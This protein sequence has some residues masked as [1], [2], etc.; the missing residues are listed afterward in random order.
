MLLAHIFSVEWL[1]S[2]LAADPLDFDRQC[3][4]AI[5]LEQ[6]I[7][8]DEKV[9]RLFEDIDRSKV[10]VWA[11]TNAYRIVILDTRLTECSSL[12]ISHKHAERVLRILQLD[13]LIDGLIYCD[14][15]LKDFSCKPEPDFYIMVCPLIV[16]LR[17]YPDN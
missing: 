6:M 3:D 17:G 16:I 5:A 13:D 1:I 11:L 9:R 8:Y 12:A 4:Q 10:R 14:Y 15:L 7:S 2:P